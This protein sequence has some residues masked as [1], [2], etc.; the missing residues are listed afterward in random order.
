MVQ[1]N[2]AL[3]KTGAFQA[4]SGDKIYQDLGMESLADRRWF[5][6]LFSQNNFKDYLI[7]CDHLRTYLTR[8]ST[9]KTIKTFSARTN[10]FESSFF[11]H[12]AE[13]WGNL[14]EELKNINSINAFKLSILNFVIPR[15]NSVFPVH[16]ING[17]K[18]LTRLRLDFSHLNEHKF[19]HDRKTNCFSGALFLS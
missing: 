10:I 12:C 17:V 19:R 5:R 7:P 1:Y 9:Q 14:P 6:S 2:A 8:S 13:A 16:D 11:P 18:L 4:A 15:K 3:I